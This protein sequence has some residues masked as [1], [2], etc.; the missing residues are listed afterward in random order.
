MVLTRADVRAS[1]ERAGEAHWRAL[2]TYHEDS[3]PASRPIIQ[4]G[5]M[6]E[7]SFAEDVTTLHEALQA[8]ERRMARG[9]VPSG[10]LAEFKSS[11]DDLRLR[12]WGLLA[13]G[14]ADDFRAFQ[15]SFRLRRA[16]E[17]CAGLAAD[18]QSG[19][20]STRHEELPALG[21]AATDLSRAIA[22]FRPGT[23]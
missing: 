20:M 15:G 14:S 12:L 22:R 23:G 21:A 7:P 10:G 13:A 6:G 19:A 2:V 18:L 11:V 4:E 9:E 17:I 5:A 8:I 1:V 3:Y 16:T